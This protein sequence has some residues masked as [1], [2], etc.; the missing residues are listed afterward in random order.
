MRVG[1]LRLWIFVAV[2]LALV[3]FIIYATVAAGGF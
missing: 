2:V 3:G 1:D